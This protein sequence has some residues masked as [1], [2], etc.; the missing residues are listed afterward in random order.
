MYYVNRTV[1]ASD[2]VSISKIF[3]LR[4]YK[5]TPSHKLS[6]PTPPLAENWS[7]PSFANAQNLLTQPHVS[8][9]HGSPPPPPHLLFDQ[10]LKLIILTTLF[11][12]DSPTNGA[13]HNIGL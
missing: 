11:G 3:L 5:I 7:D 1:L 13:F 12:T 4:F 6:R 9:A 10:P 2:M 8:P